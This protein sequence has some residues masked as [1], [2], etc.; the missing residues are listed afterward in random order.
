MSVPTSVP[1]GAARPARRRR[2]PGWVPNQHGAWAMLLAP[3][4]VGAAATGPRWSHLLLLAFWTAGYLAFFATGLWLRSH[5][6]ARY[7]PPLRV[8][9]PLATALGVAVLLVQPG[10]MRWAPLFVLPL[11]V[12]LV[13]SATRHER[14]LVSGLATTVG[15]SL[16]TLVAYDLGPG[17]DQ[18]R[19]WQLT[20][21]LAAYFAGTVL[22]VK[23]AIR[24]RGDRRFLTL[25]VAFHA[26]LTGAALLLL[27]PPGGPA[28]AA[29]GVL[30]AVR[31]YVIPTLGWSPARLGVGEIAMTL[32]VATTALLT[33]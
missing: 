28:L 9:L 10:L 6:K 20:A 27:P 25:S 19:A 7:L 33:L 24:Q 2:S 15:S 17:D 18:M 32:I 31:A 29:V 13:A 8:Y 26:V 12:G 22:Y 30:L 3:L 4:L 1:R 23:S 16:M 11:G 14:A 5:R 21:V